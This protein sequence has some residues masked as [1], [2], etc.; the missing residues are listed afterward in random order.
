MG[1]FG[2][3]S[4]SNGHKS[5]SGNFENVFENLR[6]HWSCDRGFGRQSRRRRQSGERKKRNFGNLSTRNRTTSSRRCTTAREIGGATR[7]IG[8]ATGTKCPTSRQAK[9]TR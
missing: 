5:K 4:P 8:Q 9:Q 6:H 1:R 2:P 3:Y 7:Q